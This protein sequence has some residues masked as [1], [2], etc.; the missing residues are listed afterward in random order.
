MRSKRRSFFDLNF[1]PI[2]T[3]GFEAH[4]ASASEFLDVIRA[5]RT[6]N[7]DNSIACATGAVSANPQGMLRQV[8]ARCFLQVRRENGG[9][10]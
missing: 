8:S 1:P 3:G 4:R 2:K 9:R 6:V 5:Y 7:S 10:S